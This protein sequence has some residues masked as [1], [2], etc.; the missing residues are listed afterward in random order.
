V[1]ESPRIT[2]FGAGCIGRG[3]VGELAAHSGWSLTFVDADPRLV[4]GLRSRS[5]GYRVRLTGRA[6]ATVAVHGY[7]VLHTTETVAVA[8]AVRD[9]RFAVTA[10]GG[11]HLADLAG[12][13]APALAQRTEALNL[14]VCENATRGYAVLENSLL[15]AGASPAAFACVPASVER[16]VRSVPG[17]L[18]LLAEGGESLYASARHWR[19][20]Q[21]RLAGL[22]FC[23]DL[24]PFYARKLF[25]NN[26]GHAVLA[27]EGHLAGC[28]TIPEAHALRTVHGR[29]EAVLDAAAEMLTREY[30]TDRSELDEHIRT[31][32]QFRYPNPELA[33]TIRRVGRDPLRKLASDERLVGLLRS[34]DRHGLP[35]L[36]VCRT[37]A[38]ALSYRDPGDEESMR[39]QR[40]IE[41]EGVGTVLSRVCGLVA[42]EPLHRLCKNEYLRLQAERRLRPVSM[43]D[44][45]TEE[46]EDWE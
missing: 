8:E 30:G 33:D 4:E 19:G 43:A 45:G 11:S 42:D 36:P 13:L 23:A 44:G 41:N 27:Y 22:R 28:T 38:A 7:R 1:I 26:A 6:P 39:L 10:V 18:D 12:A 24:E 5:T 20:A 2:V 37:I 35:V 25:T 31:L 17:S 21:P 3:L 16:M 32:L 29:L 40:D 15:A 46:K 34:L 9:C 14:L